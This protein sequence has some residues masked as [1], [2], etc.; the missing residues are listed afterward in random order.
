MLE[1]RILKLSPI[2][3]KLACPYHVLGRHLGFGALG[4]K[5]YTG[6]RVTRPN[7][8]I[9]PLG[10]LKNWFR[11][12]EKGGVQTSPSYLPIYKNTVLIIKHQARCLGRVD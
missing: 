3:K 7:V 8:I 2:G 4:A 11:I 1:K 9:H 12:G 10:N 5:S 6:H